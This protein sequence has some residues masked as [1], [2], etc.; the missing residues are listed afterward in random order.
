MF[1]PEEIHRAIQARHGVKRG[2]EGLLHAI[3]LHNKRYYAKEWRGRHFE[4]RNRQTESYTYTED[5]QETPVSPFWFKAKYYEASL[6]HDALPEETL[7]LEAGY[8]PRLRESQFRV[9]TGRPV[10]LTGAIESGTQAQRARDELVDQMYER[11]FSYFPASAETFIQNAPLNSRRA[12]LEMYLT[13]DELIETFGEDFGVDNIDW[14]DPKSSLL[15]LAATVRKLNPRSPLLKFYAHGLLPIHPALNFIPTSERSQPLRGVFL[16]VAIVDVDLLQEKLIEKGEVGNLDDQIVHRALV[17]RKINL[18]L[19]YRM[20][21]EI[22]D[23]YL[24]PRLYQFH[25]ATIQDPRIH[26][27]LFQI[28]ERAKQRLQRRTR[29]EIEG[30]LLDLRKNLD[31]F[32]Q[33]QDDPSR[34]YEV[35]TAYYDHMPLPPPRSVQEAS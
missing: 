9:R 1:T 11:Y 27:Q 26:N 20:L 22:F 31:S 33:T 7:N 23:D 25:R 32:F 12:Q 15:H 2:E 16:E 30:Y 13:H 17:E 34:L 5:S 24:M 14:H 29:D 18:Y 28:L 8:D 19:L 4:G 3:E 6:I 21:D 35:L 10:T